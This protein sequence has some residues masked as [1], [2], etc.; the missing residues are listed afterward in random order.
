MECLVED[1]DAMVVVIG[2]SEGDMR[3]GGGSGRW[4]IV[5]CQRS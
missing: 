5:G 2:G 1:R 3:A 4:A